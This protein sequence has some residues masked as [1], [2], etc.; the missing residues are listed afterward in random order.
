MT[1]PI[2]YSS[3][4]V[5]APQVVANS[6]LSFLQ[7]L[8][9]CLVDGYN[10]TQ[11]GAGWTCPFE[12]DT[13]PAIVFRQGGGNQRYLQLNNFTFNYGNN[14][15]YLSFAAS[16]YLTM[17][18]LNTGVGQF[19]LAT[20]QNWWT[21]YITGATTFAS[22]GATPIGWRLFAT[23]KFFFVMLYPSA[24][25]TGSYNEK[26]WY[27]FGDFTSNVTNDAYNTITNG[28]NTST[29]GAYSSP[30]GNG[31]PYDPFPFTNDLAPNGASLWLAGPFYQQQSIP[32]N[33][34]LFFADQR[35]NAAGG[36]SYYPDPIT[37]TNDLSPVLIG[38]MW[39]GRM[40]VR[41]TFPG[42]FI[43]CFYNGYFNDGQL[44]NGTGNLSG[45]TFMHLINNVGITSSPNTCPHFYMQLDQWT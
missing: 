6:P 37:H 9:A 44:F 7:M 39:N 26:L 31:P 28:W 40:S 2:V 10:A 19:P 22:V 42:I 8:K 13:Q 21:Y 24:I 29:Y 32:V 27:F 23:N 18:G 5:N 30:L 14:W 38:E 3:T 41:G 12:D 34:C 25:P 36:T 4:D 16:G 35:A 33:P 45:H 20:M 43:P 11:V 17:T 15:Y 1:A